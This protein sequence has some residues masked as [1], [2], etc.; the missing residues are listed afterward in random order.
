M[1]DHGTWTANSSNN[2]LPDWKMRERE[3]GMRPSDSDYS[4]QDGR[5]RGRQL[6]MRSSGSYNFQKDGGV[7][8]WEGGIRWGIILS[9]KMGISR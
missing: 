8:G 9:K 5:M 2:R 6:E 3:Y 1:V 7:S 4:Q